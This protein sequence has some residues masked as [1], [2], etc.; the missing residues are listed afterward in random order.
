MGFDVF[1]ASCGGEQVVH[2]P[3]DGR[4]ECYEQYVGGSF[5]REGF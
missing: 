4:D 1:E 2:N 3:S 5:H